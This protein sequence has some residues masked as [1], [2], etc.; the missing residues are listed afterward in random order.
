MAVAAE[1]CKECVEGADREES[2]DHEEVGPVPRQILFATSSTRGL[3]PR[4]LH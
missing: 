1:E 3:T 4:V 2:E